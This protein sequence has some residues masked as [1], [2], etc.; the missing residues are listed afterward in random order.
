MSHTHIRAPK[1]P[2]QPVKPQYLFWICVPVLVLGLCAVFF[3]SN[4]HASEFW[5]RHSTANGI[6][7]ETRV[8]IDHTRDSLYGGIILYRLYA[9]VKFEANGQDQDRW[10]KV[11]TGT[12]SRLELLAKAATSPKACLVYWS[13]GHL[14]NAECKIDLY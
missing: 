12:T 6:I 9:H 7:L 4:F 14:E 10:L 5:D 2:R 8:D 1:A 3:W 11:L 13:P